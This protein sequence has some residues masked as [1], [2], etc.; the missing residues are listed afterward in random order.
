MTTTLA[1][2]PP[3]LL[4]QIVTHIQTAQTL[5]HLALTCKRLHEYTEKDG[6]RVFVQ[7]RFPSIQSPPFWKD[8]AH[9]L[10]TLSRAWDRKAFIARYIEPQEMAARNSNGSNAS[11]GQGRRQDHGGRPRGQT[12]GYQPV[13]DS[14]DECT[15]NEWSSRREVL[16]WG[17]GAGL[18]M[19]IKEMGDRV[20]ES[21]HKGRRTN[22]RVRQYD[23]QH[24]HKI[25]WMVRKE[26]HY[27]EGRDDITS[28]N[29]LRPSQKQS[30]N[31]EHIITGRASGS[32]ECVNLSMEEHAAKTITNY[33]THGRAVRSASV[34][35][36][37]DPLLA[38]CL[39]DSDLAIYP[40]Y[41][42]AKDTEPHEEI[43][44]IPSGKPGRTWST[45]FLCHNRLAVGLGPSTE[46]IHI[47]DIS[48]D[49]VSNKPLRKYSAA[50]AD[51]KMSGD[52]RVD[53]TGTTASGTSSV[54]P[55]A[56][57]GPSSQAGGAEGEIFLS[58]WYDG[59]VRYILLLTPFTQHILTP[60]TP[61]SP[62]GVLLH[63]HL[64]R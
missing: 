44:V 21:Y 47:Y 57:I 42:P 17:A 31:S 37:R 48:P 14:Y 3:E 28:L 64:Q 56:P 45:R 62:L 11:F 7:T 59:A 60:Q 15:G 43:S 58:G 16:A 55:I 32:L 50:G 23:E 61:R 35:N 52:D 51:L 39:S 12:M 25:D 18:V 63:R 4:T 8:A 34:N 2:L 53:T 1:E 40:V 30:S 9:A 33:L 54:Y 24:H 26:D 27:S 46:P 10:T 22:D 20:E 41:S 19:R 49:G 38:A 5:L 36:T 29:L 6:F 13:I